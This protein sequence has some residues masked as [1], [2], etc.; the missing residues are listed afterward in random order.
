M[1]THYQNDVWNNQ[2]IGKVKS[3]IDEAFPELSAENFTA[4]QDSQKYPTFYQLF[5]DF[6][7]E[8]QKNRSDLE[9]FWL[10]FIEMV[11]NLLNV[12]YATRT[13]KWH[14]YLRS[15]RNILPYVF[16]NIIFEMLKMLKMLFYSLKDVI[17]GHLKINSLRNKFFSISELIKGKVDIFLIN[18]S[19][20]EESFPSNQFAMSGYKFINKKR[21][22]NK[23][24]GGIAFY[25]TD[26]LPSRTIK[27]ENP[28]DIE[29]LT[30]EI[31]IRKD[32][33][34]VAGIYTQPY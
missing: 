27:I 19:K 2:F 14:L 24:G 1:E 20:L 7:Q 5:L 25:I 9:K 28:S 23:F 18:K 3:K 4:F 29:I 22:L 6:K 26:Q 33:I 13:G 31:T 17:F 30:I 12:L 32:K 8:L 10:S 21:Y 34:L 11:E 15:L 16:K